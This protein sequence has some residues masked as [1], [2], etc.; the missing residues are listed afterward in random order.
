MN[1]SKYEQYRTM[2]PSDLTEIIL[3]GGCHAGFGL[4]GPQKGDGIPAITPEEQIRQSVEAI[5]AF[6]RQEA[7]D[8]ENH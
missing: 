6:M 1:R 5:C 2:L 8:A 4:Y 3:E 7:P